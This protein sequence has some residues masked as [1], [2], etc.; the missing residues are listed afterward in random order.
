MFNCMFKN[1]TRGGELASL[2]SC[3]C[4]LSA[5]G[6]TAALGGRSC[7]LGEGGCL[8]GADILPGRMP[9]GICAYS[10]YTVCMLYLE[11]QPGYCIHVPVTLLGWACRYGPGWQLASSGIA[12]S[13]ECSRRGRRPL[14]LGRANWVESRK[15]VGTIL[16]AQ[17]RL[18][19]RLVEDLSPTSAVAAVPAGQIGSG[20]HSSTHR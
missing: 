4:G 10:V 17:T 14:G 16:V 13:Y 1:G 6:C 3:L 19:A 9:R 20:L 18:A 15:Q 11:G 8:G 2:E 7:Y 5:I 12:L